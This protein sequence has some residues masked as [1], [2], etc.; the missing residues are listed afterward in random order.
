LTD[1]TYAKLL[2]RI[3]G[4]PASN[5][6]RQNIL[7]YYADLEKPFATKQTAKAW[8]DLIKKLDTLKSTPVAVASK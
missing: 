7:S 6:L 8:Q 4:K 3:S 2:Q 1:E 5:A